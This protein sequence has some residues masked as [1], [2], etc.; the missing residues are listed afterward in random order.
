MKK[1][2]MILAAF[3]SIFI[4][5]ACTYTQTKH[6]KNNASAPVYALSDAENTN[7]A[8][9]S[10]EPDTD[11]ALQNQ[12]ETTF[13][14]NTEPAESFTEEIELNTDLETDT[15]TNNA[16]SY[17]IVI[18]AGH[19]SKANNDKEPIGPDAT[20]LKAKVSGGTVG[21][22]SKLPEYE[23]TL[24]VSLKLQEELSNRGYTVIMIR[25]ENDV[26]ISNSERAM[27]ANNAN[28]DAFIRIH[29]NGWTDSRTNG[30]MTICQTPSNPYNA[31]LYEKSKKLS[32]CILDSMVSETGAKRL[33]VWE[34]D[35]MS[36][37]NW[38]TVPVTI[39]EMGY[40]TNPKEDELMA[41][42]GYQNTL[43]TGMANGIDAYFESIFEE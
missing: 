27:V 24:Q 18:D 10:T 17:V 3:V 12:N 29:A 8:R 21:C 5:S 14:N 20:E 15:D 19:Q 2:F 28:A 38:C 32:S 35:T 1:Y 4:L 26:D 39:V 13:Q 23:L 33:Y 40:M 42:E 37:I 43:V 41:T 25:T 30:I 31:N 9:P 16:T 6:V 34:T 36:G 22:V 7:S 11:T